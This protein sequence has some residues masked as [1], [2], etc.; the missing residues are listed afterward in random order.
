MERAC[1]LATWQ[2]LGDRW[3]R[4]DANFESV[5][6]SPFE[7]DEQIAEQRNIQMVEHSAEPTEYFRTEHST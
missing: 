5:Q 7:N 6:K 2:L 3:D 4:I 1:V